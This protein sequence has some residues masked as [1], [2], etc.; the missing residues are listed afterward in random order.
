MTPYYLFNIGVPSPYSLDRTPTGW[1][2]GDESTIPKSVLSS[3]D[4]VPGADVKD[5]SA[6]P[7]P[8]P[9]SK[10]YNLKLQARTTIEVESSTGLVRIS[11]KY[12]PRNM[13]CIKGKYQ[14]NF[15]KWYELKIGE[16]IELIK[17]FKKAP[18]RRIAQIS[19]AN[20][21]TSKTSDEPSPEI[22]DE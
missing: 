18:M 15:G 3:L 9:G 5:A 11:G 2:I 22:G 19:L 20:D 1:V 14:I 21:S 17:I 6:S 7:G 10:V 13:K 16:K 12:I 8:T 4:I